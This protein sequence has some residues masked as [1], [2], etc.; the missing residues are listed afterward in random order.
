MKFTLDWLKDHLETDATLEEITDT[1]T[2][3]GLELEEI[4]DPAAQFK[5]FTVAYVEKAEKH[6]DADR[7]KVCH[8]NTGKETIQ[9]VCGAPNAKEGM[10]GIFAPVGSYIPGTDM[11][12]QKGKI[13]GIESNG[14]LVSER[15]MGL[16]DDHEGI[17]DITDKDPELGTAFAEL[18]GLND[19]V[20]EIGLTPNRAD[21][22]GVRGI[23]RDLSAAGLGNL[24]DLQVDQIK[25][26]YDSPIKVHLDFKED[27]KDACPLFVGRYIKDVKNG[28]SPEWMQNRLKAIGLRP[29]SALVDITNYL[30]YNLCRP[31]HVFDADKIKGDLHL[32]MSKKGETFTGLDE[33]K[34]TLLD[35]MTVICDKSGVINLAGIMGGLESGCSD[36]TQNVFL[37]VA[38]FSPERTAKT[39]RKLGLMSDAR[40]RFERGIDPDFTIPAVDIA[41]QMI[42]DFCGGTPSHSYQAGDVPNT[43]RSITYEPSFTKKI[44]GVDIENKTQ[45]EILKKLGFEVKTEDQNWIITPPSWRGDVNIKEDIVEEVIR[46]YGYNQIETVSLGRPSSVTAHAETKNFSLVRKLRTSL[47]VRGMNEC[48][49]WSFMNAE[50]ADQFGA[51]NNQ[52]VKQLKIVNPIS[53]EMDQ[54]RPSILPNLIEAAQNNSDKGFSSCALFEVGPTF[55]NSKPNGQM[56]MA[57]GVR[58]GNYQDRHWSSSDTGRPVDVFD[59]KADVISALRAIDAPVDSLQTTR[60]AP[61]WFHPGCSGAFRLGPNILAYFGELH[62]SIL[63]SM[64]VTPPVVGFEI[65]LENIP[66]ARK[67]SSTAKPLLELSSF[68]PVK[69]DY[70]FIVDDHVEANDIVRAAKSADK[71]LITDVRIFDVYS[72]KG[73]ETGKKSIAINIVIEPYEKTLT[74]KELEVLSTKVVDNVNKKTGGTL[75]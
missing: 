49:S 41:T 54:M 8:V 53:Q 27:D 57:A 33:Q 25:G 11:T 62:P 52:S 43:S 67:K 4:D 1:L 61:E 7:L 48:I 44:T 55:I 73:V 51:Q 21:C 47:A 3:I 9:V 38:Y 56:W 72:G 68:Q 32:R 39:G 13:R 19:P 18:Y 12:L 59:A 28:P 5:P 37:E 50:R 34:Y 23:A 30:S 70:A 16:S 65:F 6:P 10:K 42:L 31:L 2:A 69:R 63:E 75:R 66:S 45:L 17:I 64:D 71:N 29:I 35:D 26:E 58:Q 60:D 24:K 20:I 40:Y 46:I 14:M 36:D 74:D 15:E 22:A